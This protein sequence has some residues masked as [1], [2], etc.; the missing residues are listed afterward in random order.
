MNKRKEKERLAAISS[1]IPNVALQLILYLNAGLVVTAA[2]DELVERNAEK[3]NPL[4]FDLRQI[5][6]SCRSSNTSFISELFAYSKSTGN[7][8]FMRMCML[9]LENSG[10]G[11]ELSRKLDSERDRLWRSKLS[12]AKARAKEAESKLC[13]P[14]AILLLVLVLISIMPAFSQM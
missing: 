4:Y 2:L 1:E 6:E 7:R 13:F 14:L 12:F 8:D 10:S 3:N 11:S 9:I 5:R